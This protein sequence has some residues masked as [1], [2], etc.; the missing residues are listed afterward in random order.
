MTKITVISD[1]HIPQRALD[2][3]SELWYSI[4][5]SKL[6]LHAGDITIQSVLNK[7]QRIATVRAVF[8]NMDSEELKYQLPEKD[9][10]EIEGVRIGL[11][12]GWGTPAE[13]KKRVRS[14]F[15]GDNI[16]VFVFGHSHQPEV[17]WES[18]LLYLNPGSPTDMIF[19]PYFSYGRL[20]I[21]NGRIVQSE[22]IRLK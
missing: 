5:D 18:G 20:V 8:G 7:L 2:L 17:N 4:V 14:L 19:A 13:V 16:Q 3:P 11:A 1:T 10:I 9:I 15:D 22:I 12:H 6:I 21:D